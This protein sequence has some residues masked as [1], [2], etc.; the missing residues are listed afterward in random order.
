MRTALGGPFTQTPSPQTGLPGQSAILF[1]STPG[2]ADILCTYI[3]LPIIFSECYPTRP[4]RPG[5]HTGNA[6]LHCVCRPTR[7]PP[8]P[9]TTRLVPGSVRI[10]APRLTSRQTI[11][12]VQRRLTT[13]RTTTP[14]LSISLRHHRGHRPR[15]DVQGGFP[16]NIGESHPLALPLPTRSWILS[17]NVACTPWKCQ[18]HCCSSHR[19]PRIPISRH[20]TP[21]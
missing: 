18:M 15:H 14:R 13:T 12:T 4:P 21:S 7:L 17:W 11:Q 10:S 5:G 6:S 20:Q 9:S 3:T 16:H 8:S 2:S 1:D 19:C